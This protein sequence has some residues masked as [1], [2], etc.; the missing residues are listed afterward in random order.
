[1]A[2]DLQRGTVKI[3]E[4]AYLQSCIAYRHALTGCM[5]VQDPEKLS[6]L[7]DYVS[8]M[9]D[10][11]KQIYY[12]SGVAQLS[13]VPSREVDGSQIPVSSQI[14]LQSEFLRPRHVAAAHCQLFR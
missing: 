12:L 3:Q 6:S 7:E 5:T 1:M 2:E 4:G 11:Q 13:P 14:I 9:K 8:R 10:D